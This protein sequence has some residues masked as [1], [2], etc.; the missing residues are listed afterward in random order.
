MQRFEGVGGEV[1]RVA[2][3]FC[4][5]EDVV[6]ERSKVTLDSFA[7]TGVVFESAAPETYV[8]F[9]AIA[10]FVAD[11]AVCVGGVAGLPPLMVYFGGVVF[12]D[13]V[14]AVWFA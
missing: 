9:D 11:G 6:S 2:F 4:G 1:D 10:Y 14:L 12:G 5:F 3:D 7:V 13:D 8:I